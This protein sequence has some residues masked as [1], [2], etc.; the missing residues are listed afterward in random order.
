MDLITYVLAAMTTW[1]PLAEHAADATTDENA[2]RY[3]SIAVDIAAV[4]EEEEPIFPKDETRA[5]S[6]IQL[7]AVAFFE[8]RFWKFVDEGD[9]NRVPFGGKH[10]PRGTCDGGHAFSLW[11]IHPASMVNGKLRRIVL[12]EGTYGWADNPTYRA[13]EA[14]KAR[15]EEAVSGPKLLADRRL[16]ARVALRMLKK[17]GTIGYTGE[18]PD[19][20]PKADARA[21]LASSWVQAHPFEPDDS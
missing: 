1:S 9:C 14:E 8:G 5:R 12:E 13:T 7:A 21:Q 10:D 17:G 4:A 3:R 18:G 15:W 20:H 2:A 19:S 11:Q 6:A 16:A